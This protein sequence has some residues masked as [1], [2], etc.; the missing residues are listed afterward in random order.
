MFGFNSIKKKISK[1]SNPLCYSFLLT[2]KT[3][4]LRSSRKRTSSCRPEVVIVKYLIYSTFLVEQQV[5]I[6]SWTHT[7]LQ[8]QKASSPNNGLFT[9]TKWTI[10]KFCR[11]MGPTVNMVA[12]IL[13]KHGL[14][15]IIE[16]NI[17][18]KT[19]RFQIE[20]I[21]A[22]PYWDW[23]LWIPATTTEARTSE[24]IQKISALV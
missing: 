19:N 13:S 5:L 1:Y 9:L 2:G 12:A 16:K 17:G 23:E 20:T 14:G 11:V 7:K 8:E 3:F 4:N 6:H 24:L 18:H 22:T 15:Y 21:K 10:K